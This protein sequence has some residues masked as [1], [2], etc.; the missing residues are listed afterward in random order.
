MLRKKNSR[1][2]LSRKEI[3][4]RF[5]LSIPCVIICLIVALVAGCERAGDSRDFSI[6]IQQEIEAAVQSNLAA[7]GGNKSVPGVVIGIW[8]PGKGEYV[9][10]IGYSDIAAHKALD[11]HDKFRVGSN[12]K[13]FVVTVI[14]QLVDDEKYQITLDD[15]LDQFELGVDIPNAG[16]I[17]VRQLCNMTSGLFEVY[18]APQLEKIF[19]DITPRTR[20]DVRELV[21]LAVKN[22]PDFPPGKGWYYSNTGYLILGLII[23]A[24]TKNRVE[25]EIRNRLLV[26]YGLKNTSFPV[27]D[28]DM[29]VP[30]SRG[31]TLDKKGN[32]EDHT[33]M[34]PPSL[35]WS[36][37]VMI[38]DMY[39]MKKWVKAYV[40][41]ST[42]SEAIQKERLE[43]VDTGRENMG[44][45]LGI[46][47]TGGWYGY[48]G[49]I[50]GYNTAAYYLPEEDATIIAFVNSQREKPSP[51]VANSI[52]R[53]I[54]KILFP[55]HVAFY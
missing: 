19:K 1:P 31:Y 37:G 39:D 20:V 10:G 22:P 45:G 35:T 44:F 3:I 4:K 54:T 13:T 49:G 17:T 14:L 23:E 29:P 43:C 40:A 25:D 5:R 32:W 27:D 55:Q 12:T 50:E 38:S 52:V 21:T 18:N 26:P 53:D 15:T 42:N 2:S 28:P 6:K 11:P 7:F 30:C 47:C 46:G 33:V 16:D 8:A 9:R 24:V 41:G 51:G 36:A 34:F 48:T